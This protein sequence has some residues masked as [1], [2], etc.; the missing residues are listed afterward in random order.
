MTISKANFLLARSIAPGNRLIGT[1]FARERI[2]HDSAASFVSP[3]LLQRAVALGAN[4]TFGVENLARTSLHLTLFK[5]KSSARIALRL[6]H[7][8]L[9]VSATSQITVF[10]YVL[11]QN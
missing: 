10:T 7:V 11:L 5:Q 2:V 8:V 3:I 9:R 6:R 1:T 4:E